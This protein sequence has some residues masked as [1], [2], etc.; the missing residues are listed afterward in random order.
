MFLPI[1]PNWYFI[2]L[3]IFKSSLIIAP[4]LI[5]NVSLTVPR[6]LWNR[7]ICPVIIEETI[8]TL[9]GSPIVLKKWLTHSPPSCL[10]R[11]FIPGLCKTPITLLPISKHIDRW[12]CGF[13]CPL[14]PYIWAFCFNW[15][16]IVQLLSHVQL[17]AAPW[18]ATHQASLSFTI[19]WSLLKLMS[20][21]SVMPSNHLI[22]C[23]PLLLLP[24][25]FPSSR[26]FFNESVLC[27][28]W[29]KY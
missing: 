25:I 29:P 14:S 9:F 18:L 5:T 12:F 2:K 22:L 3:N 28:R 27:I 13:R 17:F 8:Q 11:W 16:Q 21:E 1:I 24:S 6:L 10:Q 7:Y 23:R 19:S 26:V 4:A 15:R 20:I